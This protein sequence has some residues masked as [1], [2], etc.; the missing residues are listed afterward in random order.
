MWPYVFVR[1][2]AHCENNFY[3]NHWPC[4]SDARKRV[5]TMY[6][7][8]AY[9][10]FSRKFLRSCVQSVVRKGTRAMDELL[11]GFSMTGIASE[12]Y[13]VIPSGEYTEICLDEGFIIV[14]NGYNN[15]TPKRGIINK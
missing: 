10:G 4:V 3:I 14:R 5:A 15:N 6:L 2:L 11:R 9:I 8:Y 12:K 7:Y 13:I 1:E